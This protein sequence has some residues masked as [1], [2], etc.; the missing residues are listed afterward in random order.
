MITVVAVSMLSGGKVHSLEMTPSFWITLISAATLYGAIFLSIAARDHKRKVKSFI[1]NGVEFLAG[2]HHHG[3]FVPRR[4]ARMLIVTSL[5]VLWW[6]FV[7]APAIYGNRTAERYI[8]GAIT[9][10]HE[11]RKSAGFLPNARFIATANLLERDGTYYFAFHPEAERREAATSQQDGAQWLVYPT[12][13]QAG[14][15]SQCRERIGPQCSAFVQDVVFASGSP[16]PI[17]AAHR[18]R[19]PGRT[20]EQWFVDGGYSNNIPVDAAKNVEAKQVLIVH[21]A[22]P[23]DEGAHEPARSRSFWR[24]GRLVM[25]VGRLPGFLFER[26]QQIDRLSRQNLFVVALAPTLEHR[27]GWPN[28]A[29]FDRATVDDMLREGRKQMTMRIGM[30]ESWGQPRFRAS[31]TSPPTPEAGQ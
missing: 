27:K 26:S 14:D 11:A 25:N 21:S 20:E 23:L 9:R 30:V 28:L 3:S 5:G 31:S 6:N 24:P 12:S 29:Q 8:R 18:I 13:H 10:F 15:V 7:I 22:S 16:F 19:I 17:F 2:E 4:Y 1:R